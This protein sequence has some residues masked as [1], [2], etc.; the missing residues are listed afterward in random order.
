MANSYD[1]SSFKG[2]GVKRNAQLNE[3]FQ[4]AG[5]DP[6]DLHGIA[7][8]DSAFQQVAQRLDNPQLRSLYWN[9]V[10]PNLSRNIPMGGTEYVAKVMPQV[11]P[12][13]GTPNLPS[14]T[15]DDRF[16]PLVA[17][18]L[19][20]LNMPDAES[21]LLGTWERHN[22][23]LFNNVP[24]MQRD[25][26]LNPS[27]QTPVDAP[28][29]QKDATWRNQFQ[30]T[31]G[32]VEGLTYKHEGDGVF[33]VQANGREALVRASSG[34]GM[35]G[36][37]NTDSRGGWAVI[38]HVFDPEK[39]GI[40]SNMDTLRSTLSSWASQD[41]GERGRSLFN[42]AT[43]RGGFY[44]SND[45]LRSIV[46][47]TQAATSVYLGK[48]PQG[49]MSSK[50][51]EE[52]L[53]AV[54]QLPGYED[55][56]KFGGGNY[57][58]SQNAVYGAAYMTNE[59]GAYAT[60]KAKMLRASGR[61]HLGTPMMGIGLPMQE[62]SAPFATE[63]QARGLTGYVAMK[64]ADVLGDLPQTTGIAYTSIPMVGK[65]HEYEITA[66]QAKGLSVGDIF[67][68]KDA[69]IPAVAE[70][71][72]NR[73][74]TG[75]F[76]DIFGKLPSGAA[77]SI[78]DIQQL[79]NGNYRVSVMSYQNQF[80]LKHYTKTSAVQMDSAD[81]PA[82]SQVW[83]VMES[84]ARVA[85]E[86]QAMIA[87]TYPTRAS[88]QSWLMAN[89]TASMGGDAAQQFVQQNYVDGRLTPALEP[90]V[91]QWAT[92]EFYDG[93]QLAERQN[94]PVSTE[95]MNALMGLAREGQSGLSFEGDETPENLRLSFKGQTVPLFEGLRQNEG[96]DGYMADVFRTPSRTYQT[97]INPR[98]EGRRDTMNVSAEKLD[99][100]RTANPGLYQALTAQD[101][102]GLLSPNPARHAMLSY[103]ANSSDES[104][105][106]LEA[107]NGIARFSGEDLA[108]ARQAVTEAGVDPE[109]KAA[110]NK[111][112]MQHLGKQYMQDGKRQALEVQIGDQS[113]VLPNPA[114]F[115]NTIQATKNGGMS[116][117]P[118]G[119]MLNLLNA[120]SDYQLEGTEKAAENAQKIAGRAMEKFGD[121]MNKPGVKQAAKGM[122][123]PKYGGLTQTVEGFGL[124]E[125]IASIKDLTRQTGMS[126][127][128]I[129]ELQKQG[130]LAVAFSHEPTINSE[131]QNNLN[132]R[133]GSF[134]ED[135][136]KANDPRAAALK[137]LRGGI[138]VST[139][140][141]QLMVSDTDAD[142]Y[143][144]FI[145]YRKDKKTG[146][147][148][149]ADLDITS[150]DEI[151]RRARL[152]P[153]SEMLKLQGDIGK[154]A[155]VLPALAGEQM[156]SEAINKT[157]KY[158]SGA[159]ISAQNEAERLGKA[160]AGPAYNQLN[161][162]LGNIAR[163]VSGSLFG[164]ASPQQKMVSEAA[165]LVAGTGYQ[166]G[167]DYENADPHLQNLIKAS[168]SFVMS[169]KYGDKPFTFGVDE[170]GNDV[171]RKFESRD[172]ALGYL[173]NELVNVQG[174]DTEGNWGEKFG[175]FATRLMMP[176]NALGNQ[177][178]EDKALDVVQRA[179]TAG[180]FDKDT[181]AEFQGL[182]GAKS[183][184][185]IARGAA[186][187]EQEGDLSKTSAFMSMMMGAS[188][189]TQEKQGTAATWGLQGKLS[190]FARQSKE[191]FNSFASK[192]NRDQ[193]MGAALRAAETHNL[194]GSAQR[195]LD[196]YGSQALPPSPAEQ[197]TS[198]VQELESRP[199]EQLSDNE[200]Q[201]LFS[202]YENLSEAGRNN[203]Q[204]AD[205]GGAGMGGGDLPPAAPGMMPVDDGGEGSGG[206][207]GNS[208]TGSEG[209][210]TVHN[211]F[212][213]FPLGELTSDDV[214]SAKQYQ[215]LLSRYAAASPDER[216]LFNSREII[217][218]HRTL[219]GVVG[220]GQR[221]MREL[222]KGTDMV[223]PKGFG[224]FMET[225]GKDGGAGVDSLL[226]QTKGDV[227]ALRD[228]QIMARATGTGSTK[229][230]TVTSREADQAIGTLNSFM[231]KIGSGAEDLQKWVDGLGDLSKLTDE[232]TK[233]VKQLV[234]EYPK[235]I[236]TFDKALKI[237]E[238][239]GEAN[240]DVNTGR[241]L[242]KQPELEQMKG[243][244]GSEG[245]QKL[246]QALDANVRNSSVEGAFDTG[247]KYDLSG[248]S[249][250]GIL[251][252]MGKQGREMREQARGEGVLSDGLMGK[253]EGAAGFAG[254]LT[255]SFFDPGTL[256]GLRALQ[257]QFIS[258]VVRA[259]KEYQNQ[260]A[261]IDLMGL[262]SGQISYDSL[263]NGQYGQIM[264]R[265][266]GLRSARIAM[267]Q[268]ADSAWGGILDATLGREAGQ[269][270]G[271]TL[272]AVGMPAVGI[273]LAASR[274]LKNA[275]VANSGSW[276]AGIGLGV[277]AAGMLGYSLSNANNYQAIGDFMGQGAGLNRLLSNPAGAFG[278][279]GAGLKAM[280]GQYSAEDTA[281]LQGGTF[282][283][284]AVAAAANG[285]NMTDLYQNMQYT[286]DVTMGPIKTGQ[287]SGTVASF[288]FSPDEF[289]SAVTSQ[290]IK[291]QSSALAISEEQAS[292]LF[293]TLAQYG[294]QFDQN[295]FMQMPSAQRARQLMEAQLKGA[296]VG[297]MV[298]NYIRANGQN[299]MDRSATGFALGQILD[300]TTGMNPEQLGR[301][302]W[303]LGAAADLNTVRS[304]FNMSRLG[305][306]YTDKFFQTPQTMDY[307]TNEYTP[308]VGQ[309]MTSSP[310]ASEDD[311]LNTYVKQAGEAGQFVIAD[312]LKNS[313]DA[314]YS[315]AGRLVAQYGAGNVNT[316]RVV[317]QLQSIVPSMVLSGAGDY[318]T[319][320]QD[321]LSQGTTLGDKSIGQLN[322]LSSNATQLYS[323]GVDLSQLAQQ[324][325]AAS[326]QAQTFD[327]FVKAVD[328]L[329]GALGKEGAVQDIEYQSLAAP[330]RESLNLSRMMVGRQGVS[331]DD[332]GTNKLLADPIKGR[333]Y[334]AV[335]ATRNSIQFNPISA[336]TGNFFNGL[337]SLIE[338]GQGGEA[339]RQSQAF[340]QF[341][342]MTTNYMA[343]GMSAPQAAMAATQAAALPQ[344]QQIQ[345]QKAASGDRMML[346][347]LASQG[348]I[349]SKYQT[350]DMNTGMPMGYDN[351][352]RAQYNQI[353]DNLKGTS[354]EKYM[355]SYETAQNGIYGIQDQIYQVQQQA[356]AASYY[357]GHMGR[358]LG[359]A[360][361][362]GGGT[363]DE[364]GFV[365]GGDNLAGWASW[366]KKAGI[367]N[368]NVGNGM[369]YWQ[370]Q[371]AQDKM[372]IEQ[373]NFNIQQGNQNMALQWEQ[374]NLNNQQWNENYDL[375][376]R[377]FAF[378]TSNARWQMGFQR[379][380]QVTQQQW[381]REDFAFNRSQS[382]LHFGW[383]MEDFDR[384]AA[385]AR[386]RE[387][388]DLERQRE[389]ATI[390]YSMQQS[391]QDTQEKRFEQ[392]V[393][394]ADELYKKNK[395]KFEQETKFQQ[396]SLDLQKKHH[397]EDMALQAKRLGMS[398]EAH[399][400][401][402]QW[403]QEEQKLNE[404]KRILDRQG[405]IANNN[406][407]ERAAAAAA[408][409]AKKVA[410]LGKNVDALQQGVDRTNKSIDL[411]V[412]KGRV[413][414]D[415]INGMGGSFDKVGGAF[416]TMGESL[417]P[418]ATNTSVL[419]SQIPIYSNNLL[420][421][422]QSLQRFFTNLQNYVNSLKPPG[423]NGTTSGG[424]SSPTQG[425][426]TS[427]DSAIGY[428]ASRLDVRNDGYS[429][430]FAQ[431][432][433]LLQLIADRVKTPSNVTVITNQPVGGILSDVDKS[434]GIMST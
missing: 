170:N 244:T 375:S 311:L 21:P 98:P 171:K 430:Q 37:S 344:V 39:R 298:Q 231:E 223:A 22:Q 264:R 113:Y 57:A 165:Q 116:G 84:P 2:V 66:E 219:E 239:Q 68:R 204:S 200:R 323:R 252:A 55:A 14:P 143:N 330:M 194:G 96:G 81:M 398:E 268:Q 33:R 176:Y 189:L 213:K 318:V 159:D 41:E 266:N 351:M 89:A 281:K 312:Q 407:S 47:E 115:A 432:I 152:Q 431:M 145:N 235:M 104:R 191:F 195:L 313:K 427:G 70:G 199:L 101:A 74:G 31:L 45:D 419:N 303:G 301:A 321:F 422:S 279:Y 137:N 69:N 377:Q 400:K 92:Q 215:N 19:N 158:L 133:V 192:R 277:A 354:F 396:E 320:V 150:P 15:G 288:G 52:R 122:I 4:Q 182:F 342:G 112:V 222:G 309:R 273:G 363:L 146:Q 413:F 336:Y 254:R 8:T 29:Q 294:G 135:L 234:T 12:P 299:Q 53:A 352:S 7:P 141:N 248:M 197:L 6:T 187:G 136:V 310:L 348:K 156:D 263:M 397:D 144:A 317:S 100:I 276:G 166:A 389:R 34:T 339:V 259:A 60:E 424:T 119:A 111:A 325:V 241:V 121:Y 80:S 302:G 27:L 246:V 64:T 324:N 414:E 177:E 423:S 56:D 206:G 218:A 371:D 265:E 243:W 402:V 54:R 240:V 386:G 346:S 212:S 233:Q 258:P 385:F 132:L 149:G 179:H 13:M 307:I 300:Q 210:G 138:A 97:L 289:R 333:Q 127:D 225:F 90:M 167:V 85:A 267:G 78:E 285:E 117:G 426:K 284:A 227:G 282:F 360:S 220:K 131:W 207:Q 304:R 28:V 380:E 331:E 221:W 341:S 410:E 364:H 260:A 160:S 180:G 283:N 44:M 184:T 157:I 99:L 5:I 128:E 51:Y 75:E 118:G 296:D 224:D 164:E 105:A 120:A 305:T 356:A 242:A 329:T 297:G 247:G 357:Y 82:G 358:E 365:Q 110:F 178:L 370:I 130:K 106:K 416:K 412:A 174:I 25:R 196:M 308:W 23:R 391:R 376:K 155:A 203:M 11:Q 154:R 245:F 361:Q 123:L 420:T 26:F 72:G 24:V 183:W 61:G 175:R 261:T 228:E 232:H 392:Q 229:N 226:E 173:H 359:M 394:W 314:S 401:Q 162:Y 278:L 316:K 202:A 399:Q 107:S 58:F 38:P 142:Q 16:R 139:E 9:N 83:S 250:M 124:N 161:R 374:F 237:A 169:S 30:D 322:M 49:Q 403:I 32:S 40:T 434:Y 230:R 383:Q 381:Q 211:H 17:H 367:K 163:R 46:N 50:V 256:W 79:E 62:I 373:Q 382:Q 257:G 190:G 201:E 345:L 94:R 343:Y 338:N 208:R 262:Q 193:T 409:A 368:P 181:A 153:G 332:L 272:A 198:R 43:K 205:A 10:V 77:H 319:P 384:N 295:G 280:F 20:R 217:R 291:N 340:D 327:N 42:M 335:D 214:R 334:L 269:G 147:L 126:E 388:L 290:W 186:A 95:H 18:P 406:I 326:G 293:G 428:S 188:G 86:A 421:L 108:A 395:D 433:D 249:K 251:T 134:V 315:L 408:A 71:Y 36:V 168:Q 390:D 271:G 306:D 129:R 185:D 67:M 216:K 63:R 366:A 125:A 140:A 393:K 114:T 87:A 286:G 209:G 109:N 378:N 411:N 353:A 35:I 73:R 387:R 270:I 379:Q 292:Q 3:A 253:A 103:L 1:F 255:Q 172:D 236:S 275:D 102:A 417:G 328:K 347:Y 148:V 350:I 76:K 93:M 274:L 429:Q 362:L 48:V 369:S 418:V 88:F 405:A 372:Q 91:T 349:D 59:Q 287:I 425:I 238:A 355:P 65:S 337:Q 415:V 151:L 404:Q